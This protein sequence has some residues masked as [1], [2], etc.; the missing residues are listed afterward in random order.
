MPLMILY[1]GELVFMFLG[2]R[3]AR[4]MWRS[5]ERVLTLW[6]ER[7]VA[8]PGEPELTP[9]P[10]PQRAPLPRGEVIALARPRELERA[11]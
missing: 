4:W 1:G 7:N 11:A 3:M 8:P 10:T 9:D 5:R 2:A 6:R